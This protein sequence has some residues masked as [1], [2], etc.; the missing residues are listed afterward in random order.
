MR[1]ILYSMSKGRNYVFN[2]YPL[3][4][5]IL[6]HYQ[7]TLQLA[8]VLMWR[9]LQVL[10]LALMSAFSKTHAVTMQLFDHAYQP[11]VIDIRFLLRVMLIDLMYV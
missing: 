9:K 4:P 1:F 6:S 11:T 10:L 8:L 2:F 5:I 7:T 3:Q